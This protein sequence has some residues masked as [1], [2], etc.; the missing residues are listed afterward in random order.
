M[1][2]KEREQKLVD[3]NADR[4]DDGS[5]GKGSSYAAIIAEIFRRKYRKGD[6]E[7]RFERDEIERAAISLGIQKPKNLGDVVYSFRYRKRLPASI[8]RTE[9]RDRSWLILG[10]GD[11]K[12]R[13]RLAR[14]AA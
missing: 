10:D 12:Y 14:L 4:I 5:D 1:P 11:A 7:V 6:D 13:F 2:S 3:S 8:L 9:P